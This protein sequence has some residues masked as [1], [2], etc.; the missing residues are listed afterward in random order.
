MKLT[1]FL[2]L[3][4][5]TGIHPTI[6]VAQTIYLDTLKTHAVAPAVSIGSTTNLTTHTYGAI[7]TLNSSVDISLHGIRTLNFKQ[8]RTIFGNGFGLSLSGALFNE[9]RGDILGAQLSLFYES[10]FF[11]H[12]RSGYR[13]FDVTRS[14]AF[15]A[16][17]LLSKRVPGFG[18]NKLV[19]QAGTAAVPVTSN[20]RR[21]QVTNEE[22]FLIVHGGLGIALGKPH[23]TH[24]I[25]E[26][27][28]SF[29]TATEDAVG[30]LALIFKL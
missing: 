16:G 19:F 2:L 7:Y 17:F 20:V 12:N 18:G 3:L 13:Y 1:L 5:L 11:H 26:P 6:T 29:S 10:V 9:L 8:N 21:G 4:L 27:G 23:C 14:S 25:I 30:T 24:V 15:G 28:L 22:A